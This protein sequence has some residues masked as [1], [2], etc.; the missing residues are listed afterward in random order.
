MKLTDQY[1][2]LTK[3]GLTPVRGKKYTE[4]YAITYNHE[5]KMYNVTHIKSGTCISKKGFKKLKDCIFAADYLI[6]NA[7]NFIAN[8]LDRVQ[9]H[10]DIYN[11]CKEHN[12]IN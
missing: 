8:N 9:Q 4:D 1:Y 10:I 2:M 11:Y 12:L 5:K 6:E 7:E 3:C